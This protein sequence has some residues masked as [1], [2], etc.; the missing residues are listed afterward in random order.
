MACQESR[1]FIRQALLG[2]YRRGHRDLPWRRVRDP[3]AIWIS[4]IMLQQT[5]VE[6]VKDYYRRFLERFPTPQALAQAPQGDVMALW[7]G[8]GYYSRARNLH[9]AAQEIVARYG[10]VFPERPDEVRGLPG[11]GPYT[12]GAILSIAFGQQAALVDGNVIR[13]LSR[14]FAI[15]DLGAQGPGRNRYWRLA[16]SLVPPPQPARE[17]PRGAA[18]GNDPGD[19]NQALM[20]LGATVCLPQRPTCLVC[21]LAAVCQARAQ[22]AVERFPPRKAKRE[23]PQVELV[24]LVLMHQDHAL[25]LR[26]PAAGLWGGLYEPLTGAPDP[27]EDPREA[28]VR[29]AGERLGLPLEPR[30]RALRALPPFQRELTHRHMSFTP[31]R[32]RL[33][34][35]RP[36][37]RLDGAYTD[38]CW[39]D[40]RAPVALGLSA[41]VSGLL[42]DM[43]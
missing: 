24:T 4:E 35:A 28:V 15:D 23:V 43:K 34:G 29:L 41:W 9:A 5:R 2:W 11:I 42:T 8:L 10:G 3:Y 31:Y 18:S 21:P 6:T 13:V 39:V 20:E 32:L 27:G 22:G 19:F 7:S 40:L 12:A 16:E 25:L 26:R 30:R 1:V 17:G 14:L 38:A 33:Q 36:E 37:L